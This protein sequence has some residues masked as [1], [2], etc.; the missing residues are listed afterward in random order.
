MKY[1]KTLLAIA[2]MS[3][4]TMSCSDKDIFDKEAYNK[5]ITEAFPVKNID[6]NQTWSTISTATVKLTL[7]QKS[8]GS[9]L[10][11]L[12]D[13]NPNESGAKLYAKKTMQNGDTYTTSINYLTAKPTVYIQVTSHYGYQAV[14]TETITNGSLIANIGNAPAATTKTRVLASSLRTQIDGSYQF[15]SDTS[16]YP[17]STGINALNELPS[18]SEEIQEGTSYKVSGDFNLNLS[19][20]SNVNVYVSAGERTMKGDA[21]GTNNTLYVLAGATLTVKAFVSTQTGNSKIVICEGATLK[22]LDGNQMKIQGGLNVYNGGTI[23]A[24]SL[25]ISESSALYNKGVITTSGDLKI[26]AEKEAIGSTASQ[27][28]NAGTITCGGTF[29]DNGAF[30][31]DTDCTLECTQ[32]DI[33]FEFA[34]KDNAWINN[35][36]FN[37]T[38]DFKVTNIS[39]NST[40]FINN[41]RLNVGG[42]MTLKAPIQF[43][44]EGG[45]Y[46]TNDF[47]TEAA[48]TI[49]LAGHSI[50]KCNNFEPN[51]TTVTGI[52]SELPAL[53]IAENNF[54]GDGT[55]VTLAGSICVDCKAYKDANFVKEE[56]SVIPISGAGQAD[57]EIDNNC[58]GYYKGK[59]SLLPDGSKK[60]ETGGSEDGSGST[61]DSKEAYN[62]ETFT[63]QDN[64]NEEE[65]ENGTIALRYCFEDNFPEP[66]DYDM[67]DLV[68]DIKPIDLND[69]NKV[70]YDISLVAVG[71]TK[72][73][74]GALCLRGINAGDINSI[75][76]NGMF[77]FEENTIQS[78]NMIQDMFGSD[79]LATNSSLPVIYLFND[80]HYAMLSANGSS[81]TDGSYNRRRPFINTV[82]NSVLSIGQDVE[83]ISSVSCSIIV[84]FDSEEA[85]KAAIE[86]TNIDPFI[87]ETSNGIE[88]E[89]HT[90]SYKSDYVLYDRDM[91]NYEGEEV[92]WAIQTDGDFAYPREFINIAKDVNSEEPCAYPYFQYW[93]HNMNNYTDW[94]KSPTDG[95]TY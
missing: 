55:E 72:Q 47:K 41:C 6:P 14:Y 17:D 92:T 39:Q 30:Y 9:N 93:A 53:I 52:S 19:D 5:L 24:G 48:T 69:D 74:A 76:C 29:I 59:P 31:N 75:E 81:T 73:L 11:C 1:T 25:Y 16:D 94:Y 80:A 56:G 8:D 18:K 68:L 12:Y 91:A 50:L 54:I 85:K 44:N 40:N 58:A 2:A 61:G 32:C 13:R 87:I 36:T 71:S 65:I 64:P 4:L 79:L 28:V 35:G 34:D 3:A 7:N 21:F 10:V 90:Y 20:K 42:G 45:V 57:I 86:S 83:D 27:L 89:V 66:G 78:Y 95:Q 38:G 77:D 63:Q 49:N 22:T 88:W 82:R 46:V 51:N 84:Q 37:T 67:N 60:E 43:D 62:K 26:D 70:R 23:D 33:T 15:N